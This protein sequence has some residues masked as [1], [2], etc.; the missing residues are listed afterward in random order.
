MNIINKELSIKKANSICEHMKSC[1]ECVSVYQ[2]NINKI[3]YTPCNYIRKMY[4]ESIWQ[5]KD[6]YR[7]SKECEAKSN[8]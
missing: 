2:N 4:G 6:E 3:V 8:E 1:E 5:Y 7:N